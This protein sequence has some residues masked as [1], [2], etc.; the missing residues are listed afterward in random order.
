MARSRSK[1]LKLHKKSLKKQI[2]DCTSNVSRFQ[3]LSA[4]ASSDDTSLDDSGDSMIETS[5][6]STIDYSDSSVGFC[7]VDECYAPDTPDG[8]VFD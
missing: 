1:Q 6:D 4:A 5:Y 3:S 8:L 2:K 7:D